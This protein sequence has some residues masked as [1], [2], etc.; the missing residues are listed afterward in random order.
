[1]SIQEHKQAVMDGD[2]RAVM[3]SFFDEMTLMIENNLW[4]VYK[5]GD[6]VKLGHDIGRYM[7]TLVYDIAKT[8][9]EIED[10]KN[11]MDIPQ[12]ERRA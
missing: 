2:G 6:R 7:D 10:R 1:M 11:I 8:L 4:G 12:Q 5:S 9:Q 3:E